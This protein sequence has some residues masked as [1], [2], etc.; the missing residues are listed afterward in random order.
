VLEFEGRSGHQVVQGDGDIKTLSSSATVSSWAEASFLIKF[1]A[2][3]NSCWL[4]Q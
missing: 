2:V 4:P 1:S 3:A